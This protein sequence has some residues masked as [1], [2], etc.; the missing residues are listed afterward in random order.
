M[1]FFLWP[2]LP[3]I[4]ATATVVKV[5]GNLIIIYFTQQLLY[6]IGLFLRFMFNYTYILTKET[7]NS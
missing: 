7:N 5:I 2:M 6:W 1:M 3:L 4:I